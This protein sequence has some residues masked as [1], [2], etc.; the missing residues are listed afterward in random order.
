MS[1]LVLISLYS[2]PDRIVAFNSDAFILT[3]YHFIF[4]VLSYSMCIALF[5]GFEL[6]IIKKLYVLLFV[7]YF[8]LFGWFQYV[9][10]LFYKHIP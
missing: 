6:C 10:M 7:N 8:R 2:I 3:R 1:C 4:S 9:S 5:V